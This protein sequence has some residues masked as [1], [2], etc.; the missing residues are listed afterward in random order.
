MNRNKRR[1]YDHARR[2]IEKVLG[3]QYKGKTEQDLVAFVN[4][5]MLEMPTDYETKTVKEEQKWGEAAYMRIAGVIE[6]KLGIR[7]EG[8]TEEDLRR[9][10]KCHAKQAGCKVPRVKSWSNITVPEKQI[11]RKNIKQS[12]YKEL[13]PVPIKQGGQI[14]RVRKAVDKTNGVG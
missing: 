14:L 4:S 13:K 5:H 2:R 12:C 11:A 6:T 8:G 3:Y 9:F 10:V 1:Y 7:F